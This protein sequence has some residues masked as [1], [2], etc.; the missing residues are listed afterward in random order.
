MKFCK[1]EKQPKLSTT[2]MKENKR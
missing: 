2:A 1:F